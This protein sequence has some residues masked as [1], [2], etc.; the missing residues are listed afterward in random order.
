GLNVVLVRDMTDTMYNPA[1]APQVTHCRG[2][3]LVIEHIEKYWCPS[4]LSS[5]LT[6]KPAFAF[7]E[8]K[9]PH[10]VFVIGEDE[11]QTNITLP[12]FAADELEPRGIRCSFVHSDE[13]TPN[14]FPLIDTLDSADVLVLSVRRRTPPKEQLDVIRRYCAAGKPVVA[15]RTASH[16]F[17]PR[18]GEA[19]PDGHEK[20]IEFD[21]EVLGAKYGGHYGR[22]EQ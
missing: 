16:A 15:V 4:I 1:R 6:G 21:T 22:S 7:A 5:D 14:Q 20:W 8:D 19:V 10:A 9:R 2:T 11:Y 13:R 18:G 12:Q 3:D 17:A